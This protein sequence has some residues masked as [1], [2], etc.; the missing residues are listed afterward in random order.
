[1]V[2]AIGSGKK[3]QLI[4]YDDLLGDTL[5]DIVES[6]EAE[7]KRHGYYKAAMEHDKNESAIGAVS[8]LLLLGVPQEQASSLVRSVQKEY[9]NASPQDLSDEAA[10]RYYQKKD[11]SDS[12]K[13]SVI[14]S[15]EEVIG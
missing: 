15:K 9:P 1:M 5:E 7:A 4:A 11:P 13:N 2:N 14:K 12:L 10:R 8:R 3:R 6:V